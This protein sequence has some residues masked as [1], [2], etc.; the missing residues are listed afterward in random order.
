VV[1]RRILVGFNLVVHC[2]L[3]APLFEASEDERRRKGPGRRRGRP[4]NA[5]QRRLR[6]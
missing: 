6:G 3:E 5:R 1:E 2:G 4:L